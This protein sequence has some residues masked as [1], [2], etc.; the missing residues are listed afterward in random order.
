MVGVKKDYSYRKLVFAGET[1]TLGDCVAIK[2]RSGLPDIT[3]YE[4]Q[5]KEPYHR[6]SRTT[7]VRP[8]WP[9]RFPFPLPPCPVDCPA[10]PV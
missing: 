4:R 9:G 5:E 3:Q 1:F 2:V 6:R 7:A 10:V 8:F